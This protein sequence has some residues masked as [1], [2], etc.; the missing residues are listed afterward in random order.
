MYGIAS[1]C[2]LI[3]RKLIMKLDTIVFSLVVEDIQTVAM[4]TLERKLTQSE[5]KQLID[6]IHNNI[7]WFDAVQDAILSSVK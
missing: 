3:K 7:H 1:M 5:L 2:F 4:E 6:P